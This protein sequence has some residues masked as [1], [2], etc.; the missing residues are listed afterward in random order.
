MELQFL[1]D[2]QEGREWEQDIIGTEYTMYIN[3]GVTTI[4]LD[5]QP[6][7]QWAMSL[8]QKVVSAYYKNGPTIWVV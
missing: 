8:S 6:T 4:N 1:D 7:L 5:S 2:K 3:N